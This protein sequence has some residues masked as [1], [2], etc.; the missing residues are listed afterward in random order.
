MLQAGDIID[1]AAV[2]DPG[3]H[4]V[5]HLFLLGHTVLQATYRKIRSKNKHSHMCVYMCI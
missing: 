3:Y 5:F 4:H 1:G 2:I